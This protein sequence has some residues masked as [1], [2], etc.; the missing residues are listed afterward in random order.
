MGSTKLLPLFTNTP[1]T[2]LTVWLYCASQSE[3]PLLQQVTQGWQ[4]FE[5]G[6]I[7]T[8]ITYFQ[9]VM[10]QAEATD[11]AHF[12]EIACNS[13]RFIQQSLTDL[14]ADLAAIS[15]PAEIGLTP[16]SAHEQPGYAQMTAAENALHQKHFPEALKLLDQALHQFTIRGEMTGV[17]Q[18]LAA[19][20][21][22][23]LATTDDS[24]AL[25][26]G[27]A[28]IA[29]LEDSE[30]TAHLAQ[31]RHTLGLAN[32]HL[33][34]L[35]LA[36]THLEKAATL[37][38]RLAD[39]SAEA[40]VL[41]DLGQVYTQQKTLMFA[42]ATYEAALDCCLELSAETTSALTAE[43]L[44]HIGQLYESMGYGEFAFA[45]YRDALE[46]YRKLGETAKANRLLQHL[47]NLYETQSQYAAALECYAQ[48]H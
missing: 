28:A 46:T 14:E 40:T 11:D 12:M 10:V 20:A 48:L 44:Q 6:A 39:T 31:A 2:A 32:F 9:D 45:P 21:K 24:R 16:E 29:V 4:H 36:Q 17:G 5:A 34:H 35:T 3:Q 23:H 25:T 7:E 30:A 22:V 42:L 33:G 13:L 47:G 19:M 27:Q 15:L 18:S 41:N 43:V 1:P 37:Y 26:Y 38:H 8:A